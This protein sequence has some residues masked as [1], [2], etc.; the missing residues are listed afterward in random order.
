MD[1]EGKTYFQALDLG[2]YSNTAVPALSAPV[3]LPMA[4]S[5]QPDLIRTWAQ[6]WFLGLS[7]CTGALS[8]P[9]CICMLIGKIAY[10]SVFVY[11]F[12]NEFDI[13]HACL[14]DYLCAC[15]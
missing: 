14:H 10:I 7:C 13:H 1:R 5:I 12:A 15:E 6:I 8:W 3:P 4:S 2:G 9:E 11:A